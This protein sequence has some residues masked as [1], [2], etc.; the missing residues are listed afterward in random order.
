MAG[1]IEEVKKAKKLFMFI[2]LLLFFFTIVT[3]MVA[4]VEWLDFGGHG[5]DAVDATIGLVIA[6]FKASLVMLIFMH[7]NHERPLIYLFFGLGLLMAFFC[8]WLIGW[9]KSDPIQF[10]NP[11]SSDGF[12]NPDK[13]STES[14]H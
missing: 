7:L 4:S 5:F 2:G 12:Y 6:T 9:S 8:M 13:P 10:G 14:H 11:N 1:S 3:V